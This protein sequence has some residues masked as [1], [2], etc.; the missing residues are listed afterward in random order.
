[1]ATGATCRA[2]TAARLMRSPF[3]AASSA[4]AT[5]GRPVPMRSTTGIA[6]TTAGSRIAAPPGGFADELGVPPLAHPVP[7]PLWSP[8]RSRAGRTGERSQGVREPPATPA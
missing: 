4:G 5:S 2:A 1:M 7:G 8:Q 6:H 3:P